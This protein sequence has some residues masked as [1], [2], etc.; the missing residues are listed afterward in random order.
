MTICAAVLCQHVPRQAIIIISDRML[1]IGDIEY[2]TK[3]QAKFS[4]AGFSTKAAVGI[5]PAGDMHAHNAILPTVIRKFKEQNLAG[6]S[7]LHTRGSWPKNGI[8]NH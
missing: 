7:W 8:S 1:T 3:N 5:H 2:E 6:A 4:M